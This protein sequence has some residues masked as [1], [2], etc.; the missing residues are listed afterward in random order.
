DDADARA[1]RVG[2]G[3]AYGRIVRRHQGEIARRMWRFTRDPAAHADLVQEV[4]VNAYR[5]LESY[6]ELAPFAHWLHKVAVRTG[7]AFWKAKARE[8]VLLDDEALGRL[9]E[10]ATDAAEA[11][12]VVH[13]ALATLP[14]RDRLVLTLMYLEGRSQAEIAELAGWSVTMVKVQAWRA[15]GKLKRALERGATGGRLA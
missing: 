4:F 8:P 2:D 12:D 15:R 9:A 10:P 7:Y 3:A 14:P 1:A 5:S 11:A 6:R 13:R